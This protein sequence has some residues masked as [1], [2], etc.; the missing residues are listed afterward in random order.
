MVNS[1]SKSLRSLSAGQVDAG[2]S[3]LASFAAG[4]YAVFAFDAQTLGVYALFFTAWNVA[5]VVPSEL[6]FAPAQVLAIRERVESRVSLIV[7]SSMRGGVGASLSAVF[8]VGTALFATQD[9]DRPGLVGLTVSAAA[10]AVLSPVQEHVRKMF[11]IAERS[12]VAASMST[13]QFAVTIVS[14]V[15][16]ALLG[17]PRWAPFGSIAIGNAVS[18]VIARPYASTRTGD[19]VVAPRL[20]ELSSIGGWLVL[21]SFSERLAVFGVA[22]VIKTLAGTDILGFAEAARVV[23]RP[24]Q[25][26]SMGLLAV[27]GPRL[28][29]AV[30]YDQEARAKLRRRYFTA[31]LT[32]SS[33]YL[34][35]AG[36]E[37]SFSPL[38]RLLTTAYAIDGLALMA[39]GAAAIGSFASP[40]LAE[41]LG[42]QRQRAILRVQVIA[43]ALRAVSAF[44]AP[45]LGA[46]TFPV[47][48]VLGGITQTI[49]FRSASRT[50]SPPN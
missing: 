47:S 44:S 5:T 32:F 36:P 13:L 43:A 19:R 22:V 46:F 9:I 25:V 26:V 30:V 33:V 8:V 40:Y 7:S 18:L 24:V 50:I 11:H 34:L 28:M 12:W 17:D 1:L 15:A 37:W 39:I 10:L 2:L 45:I 31:N 42:G 14:L 3:S 4:L 16:I 27:I 48:G 23:A 21:A 38:P 49:G 6:I 20:T 29:D 41:L 35:A